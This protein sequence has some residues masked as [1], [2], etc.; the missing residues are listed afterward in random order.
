MPTERGGVPPNLAEVVVTALH[1][2]RSHAQYLH[3]RGGHYI[4]TV[5]PNQPGLYA[6]VAGLPWAQIAV[7]Y[8]GTDRGHGRRETR[9]LEKTALAAAADLPTGRR[10]LRSPR[11]TVRA[12][13]Q[14]RG[15]AQAGHRRRRAAAVRAL[16]VRR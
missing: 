16:R 14:W 7:A 1:A 15:R 8:R 12:P 11:Q 2:V 3:D 4:L 9:T 5:K 10:R 13:R 6:Q